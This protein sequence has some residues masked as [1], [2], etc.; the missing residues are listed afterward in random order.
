MSRGGPPNKRAFWRAFAWTAVPVVA[1][2]VIVSMGGAGLEGFLLLWFAAPA[3]WLVMLL[4]ASPFSIAR[5]RLVVSGVVAGI[6]VGMLSLA[7]TC[8]PNLAS[9]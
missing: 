1:L 9:S 4:T 2:S 8:F 5:H 7:L 3:W 6:G